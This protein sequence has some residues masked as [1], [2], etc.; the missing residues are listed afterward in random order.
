V[1][2][3]SWVGLEIP[4]VVKLLNLLV[5][6]VFDTLANHNLLRNQRTS[7]RFERR[8]ER[9]THVVGGNGFRVYPIVAPMPPSMMC[10]APVVKLLSVLAR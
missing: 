2:Q 4:T 10:S 6:N 7:D 8:N 5:L 9:M 3:V 1:D